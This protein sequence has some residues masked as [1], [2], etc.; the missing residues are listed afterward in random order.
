MMRQEVPVFRSLDQLTG[1][2]APS[3]VG[4]ILDT[5][6]AMAAELAEVGELRCRV[7]ELTEDNQDKA[8]AIAA[9]VREVA[10]LR[11]KLANATTERDQLR[12][13]V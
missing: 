2:L 4:R 9:L 12:C 8:E 13:A 6:D 1:D 5:A 11:Q 3:P 10:G 7:Q